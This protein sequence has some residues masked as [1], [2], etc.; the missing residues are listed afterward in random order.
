MTI[1]NK[2]L[3]VLV[4]LTVVLLVLTILV[5]AHDPTRSSGSV[6][7]DQ[8]LIQGLDVPLI[9]KIMVHAEGKQVTLQRQDD[10]FVVAEREN[11]PASIKEVN[12]LLMKVLEI[13]CHEVIADS[14]DSHKELGVA[15]DAKTA[16]V[17][18][19]GKDGKNLATVLIGSSAKTGGN[20]VRLVSGK[21]SD[22][23]VYSSQEGIWGVAADPVGYLRKRLIE[24]PEAD[25]VSVTVAAGPSKYTISRDKDNKPQLQNVPAGKR[26]KSQSDVDD[27]FKGLASLDIDDVTRDANG[28]VWA[29]T[30]SCQLKSH[31]AYELTVGKKLDKQYVKVKAV[32]P[33]DEQIDKARTVPSDPKD[34]ATRKHNSDVLMA[35]QTAQ[36]F[37]T[38]QEGWNYQLIEYKAKN[39]ARPL[40]DLVEDIPAATRPAATAPAATTAPAKK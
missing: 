29:G 26:V 27:V 7:S 12:S 20:Y 25:I 1:T 39:F 36:T 13:R 37:N 30:Y 14:P 19:L 5:L 33:S 17:E 4:G 8:L 22:N 35:A 18:L 38:S 11:Y 2:S 10:R 28:I 9:S 24:A 40:A 21:P 32:G 3:S 15:D 6:K 16:K 31:L 23:T 34:E